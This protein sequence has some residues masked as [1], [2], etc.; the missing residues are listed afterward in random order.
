MELTNFDRYLAVSLNY[1]H[2]V[3]TEKIMRTMKR[4]TEEYFT[5]IANRNNCTV[6]SCGDDKDSIDTFLAYV[7]AFTPIN[8]ISDELYKL[9]AYAV[10][11]G[12][13]LEIGAVLTSDRIHNMGLCARTYL[14][15]DI[16]TVLSFVDYLDSK[17]LHYL[18]ICKNS[19]AAKEIYAELVKPEVSGCIYVIQHFSRSGS[20]LFPRMLSYFSEIS[21]PVFDEELLI[22][23]F[24]SSTDEISSMEVTRKVTLLFT[25]LHYNSDMIISI[26]KRL[27]T[28]M[29]LYREFGSVI[30]AAKFFLDVCGIIET[31]W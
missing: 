29:D 11:K 26:W 3:L 7:C 10:S 21:Q 2:Q 5:D 15:K 22:N 13:H 20:V 12:Y 14:S 6:H 28:D 18:A 24:T 23:E 31:R 4:P 19:V 27:C 25:V 1:G 16:H 17:D 9:G 30:E 8:M